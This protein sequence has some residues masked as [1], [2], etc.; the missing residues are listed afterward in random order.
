MFKFFLHTYNE[1]FWNP[2]SEGEEQGLIEGLTITQFAEK[3]ELTC[4]YVLQE[5]VID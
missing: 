4:D 1:L 5:F 2:D 3:H